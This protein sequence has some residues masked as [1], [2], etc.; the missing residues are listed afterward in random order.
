MEPF[1]NPSIFTS[2]SFP[3]HPN[4]HSSSLSLSLSAKLQMSKISEKSPKDC[5]SKKS[6]TFHKKLNKKLFFYLSTLFLSLLSFIFLIWLILHPSKPQ[7]SLKEASIDQLN[8]TRP[9]FLI[10][11]SI[12]LTLQSQNPNKKVGIYYDQI[13]LYA[14]YKGQQITPDFPISPFYQDHQESNLLSASLIG[15]QLPV[16]PSFAYEVQRDQGSGRMALSFKAMGKL[17]WKVGTWVSGR[18]RFTVNC[19]TI[20]PLVSLPSPPLH[21]KQSS[22]CSTAM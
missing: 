13:L 18:Y 14:S 21:S 2:P 1:I 16:A 12:Q 4:L 22:E 3:Q 6:I 17:R 11:S 5:A 10:D 20:L 15:F 8:F 19:I 9:S 7:F